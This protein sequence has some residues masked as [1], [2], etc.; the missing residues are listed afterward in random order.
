MAASVP[1]GS[2]LTYPVR[3]VHRLC[4]IYVQTIGH[5]KSFYSLLDKK[6]DFLEFKSKYDQQ[7]NVFHHKRLVFKVG[8][9]SFFRGDTVCHAVIIKSLVTY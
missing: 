8:P 2:P 4:V 3:I 5:T 9:R 7:L 1:E 6:G